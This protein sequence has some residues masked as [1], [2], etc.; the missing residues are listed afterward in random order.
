MDENFPFNPASPY[1]V[2]KIAAYYLVRYYR[3][4]YKLKVA[5]GISFNHESPLR[6]ESFIT[7]KITKAVARIKIG[8][9]HDIYIGNLYAKRD[10]GHARDFIRAFW[11][12]NNQDTLRKDYKKGD[13]FRDYVVATDTCYSVK[14]FLIK[15]FTLAGY[16]NL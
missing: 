5:T 2:A 13:P 6:H 10:W 7:R 12:I 3:N 9:Q 8:L 14:E 15:A 1:A 16:Q 4:V 11:L